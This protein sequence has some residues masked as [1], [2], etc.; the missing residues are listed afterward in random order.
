ML[1]ESLAPDLG[2]LEALAFEVALD[3]HLGG[4]PGMVG[5]DHPQSVLAP[6]PLPAGEHVLE[7]NVERVADME[8]AGDVGRRHDNRPRLAVAA[9]RTEEAAAL[10]MRVPA[11]LDGFGVEGLGKLTHAERRLAAGQPGSNR[12]KAKS[13]SVHVAVQHLQLAGP[14]FAFEMSGERAD[15]Q[16]R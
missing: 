2:T 12:P 14:V 16:S 6:Q 11:L 13:G 5:A 8:R 7:R 10:P 9:L 15:I 1:E 4:D 3:H